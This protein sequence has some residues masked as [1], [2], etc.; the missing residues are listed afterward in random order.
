[1]MTNTLPTIVTAIQ[2][3]E[4]L[5]AEQQCRVALAEA[6]DDENLLV[7][8]AVCLQHQQRVPEAMAILA[9]LTRLHPLS[10]V[11]WINYGVVL[12]SV[13]NVGDAEKAYLKAI[14]L[15]PTNPMPRVRQGLLLLERGESLAAR[16]VLLDAVALDKS[17]VWARIQAARAC[18][19]SQDLGGADDMLRDWRSW[20][21]LNNDALQLD[22]A[23]V[24][25][26]KGEVPEA[27][28]L[29]EDFVVRQPNHLEAKVLLAT[30]Y[31][32]SNRLAE[33]QDLAES[34]AKTA[35]ATD[36]QRNEVDH[37]LATLKLRRKDP[38]GAR[39]I[40]E[41]CGPQGDDDYAHFFVL[42]EACD[43]TGDHEAA[44]QALQVAHRLEAAERQFDSPERFTA[45]TP[46]LHVAAPRVS[47]EQ[48]HRWPQLS[49]PDAQ[50]S[51]IFVVGF[52]RS[53]TTLLEQMLDAHPGLQSMDENPFFNTLSDILRRH[54]PRILEDLSVL[55]Q[56]DCDELRKRYHT[57]V[58]ERI[59]RRDGTRLVDKNPLN[60]QWLGMIHRLFPEAKYILAVRH[61]CDVILSCYMQSFRASALASACSTLE[62]LA[63]AYVETMQNWLTENEVFRPS[64]MVSR[65]EDLVANFPQQVERIAT[66]LEIG[67]AS[68]MLSFDQHARSKT[69]IGTPSY[70]QVIEPVN[71]KG[72]GRWQN[73]RRHFEPVLPILEPMLRH[74]G[75]STEAGQ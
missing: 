10:S 50:D 31:E 35:D 66:F 46:A 9:K 48:Y 30:A 14:H 49:A 24:L 7:L 69:Y 22:L 23:Q 52:P 70:S 57:L 33:A 55:R 1:M 74:W 56:Y 21:P 28:E 34:V 45:E 71:R 60:M 37:L 29:L 68:S 20:L 43:K 32:R 26:L 27:T 42:G 17:S 44:M 16:S 5:Q 4:V 25:V 15:D 65:Y 36:V 41:R 61:P 73:Y 63:H 2:A 3:G 51:P 62:R 67:D 54:D 6:P 47:A 38:K 53:G 8:L 64:V 39:D 18:C 59:S 12:A 19:V 75:Y 11:H 13:G 72:L 58:A 40:L